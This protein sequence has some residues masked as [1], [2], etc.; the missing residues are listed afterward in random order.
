MC[1]ICGYIGIDEDGLLESMTDALLHRGPDNAGYY[2]EG[3][4]GL[5]H[6]RLSII[7]IAGGDQPIFNED[8]SLLIIFNGEIF[9]YQLLRQRLID[10]GH[11]FRTNSDTEVILH[12]YEDKGPECLHDLN[13]QFAIAI[14]DRKKKSLFLARD[15]LGINPLYYVNIDGQF[16]FAS[17]FKSILRYRGFQT[18]LNPQSIHDY[19]ALR[20]VPG[21]GSM[22]NEINKLPAGHYAIVENGSPKIHRYWKPEICSGP[23]NVSEEDCLEGLA[24][25]F[26]RSVKRRL[27]SE[28][29]VGAYLSG[30]LDSSVI[31][32]AFSKLATEPVRTFSVGFDFEH[33]ELAQAAATAKHLGCHHTEIACRAED[34]SLLPEITYHLDEPIGDGI[35]IPLY[36][37]ARE[38]KKQVSVVLTGD[39]A[40]E[41]LGGYLFHKALLSGHKLA[42]FTPRFVREK[43]LGPAVSLAPNMLMNS[44]FDYPAELGQRGKL[45]I[46]DYLSLLEPDQLPDAYRHLTS[47]FDARDTD[48]LY[49]DDFKS[50]LSVPH[51]D[52]ER[53][54]LHK[55]AP[56]LNRIIDLQFEHW[57]PDSILMKQDK[58]AMAHSIEGRVPFLDHELV[59]YALKLPPRLKIRGRT[60]KY[61]LRRYGERML[62]TAVTARRKQ[63]FYIPVENYFSQ[64][65]FQEMMH[66]TLSDQSVRQ[67]GIVRPEAVARL[68][69]S[70]E[71]GEFIY[72]KQVLSLMI[73]ELWFRIMFDQ[74][75]VR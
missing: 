53:A 50:R 1:G 46:A 66:D 7:D 13:G 30:G 31:V 28:V 6:R 47:L 23:F 72:A 24:E 12:L 35:V 65:D 18:S 57:L 11:R 44:V 34:I 8:D 55:A 70:M 74:R 62:P 3:G 36:L 64:P 51:Q 41:V 10:K 48:T 17:E 69:K 71:S 68:R 63:P 21:P 45:K 33:D 4:V 42:R 54:D 39:G 9:N 16:L 20:Y 58:M 5:G 29:P 75:G 61:L 32:A 56:F 40:D 25:Q 38:A 2:R 60:S 37:L 73:L 43:I 14:Y 15:R 49:T 19:L 27:I 26:E 67:R 59:E 52:T 22:F